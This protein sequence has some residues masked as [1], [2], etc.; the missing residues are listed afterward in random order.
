MKEE[1]KYLRMV[2][3]GALEVRPPIPAG[4]GERWRQRGSKKYTPSNSPS[5]LKPCH[6][7]EQSRGWRN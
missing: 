1:E 5:L 4:R 2:G 6:N 3:A 7:I